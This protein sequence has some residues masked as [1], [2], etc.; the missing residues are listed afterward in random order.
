MNTRQSLSKI[1]LY[2]KAIATIKN[3]KK[4]IKKALDMFLYV[5]ILAGISLR[6]DNSVI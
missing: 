4:S 1:G 2:A 5:C 3:F 6:Y